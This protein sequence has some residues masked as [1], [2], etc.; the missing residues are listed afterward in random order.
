MGSANARTASANCPL[1]AHRPNA[2]DPRTSRTLF[3]GFAM[4]PPAGAARLPS[5]LAEERAWARAANAARAAARRDAEEAEERE[6]LLSFSLV[7]YILLK[8][9][10]IG[11]V[12]SFSFSSKSFFQIYNFIRSVGIRLCITDKYV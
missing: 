8:R 7:F 11:S 9:L 3:A 2:W 1:S 4:N 12:H 5:I 10:C 6:L